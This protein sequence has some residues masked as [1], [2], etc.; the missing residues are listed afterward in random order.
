MLVFKSILNTRLLARYCIIA[1]IMKRLCKICYIS[2]F[3]AHNINIKVVNFT[4]KHIIYSV[5]YSIWS[6]RRRFSSKVSFLEW[7][8]FYRRLLMVDTKSCGYSNSDWL[9][10]VEYWVP[11]FSIRPSP[12]K[13]KLEIPKCKA[14][15]CTTDHVLINL[16]WIQKFRKINMKNLLVLKLLKYNDQLCIHFHQLLHK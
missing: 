6:Y 2:A 5:F 4:L 1:H 12:K 10:E 15:N 13:N 9:S 8:I 14:T 11:F 16:L 3:L 7:T